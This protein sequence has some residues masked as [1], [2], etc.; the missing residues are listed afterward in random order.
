MS[1]RF[2]FI[3]ADYINGV[4]DDDGNCLIRP[5]TEEEK[6]FLNDFYAETVI[7]NFYHHP[8][9]RKLHNKKKALVNNDPNIKKLKKQSKVTK[10]K[11][12]NRRLKELVKEVKSQ[13]KE[14]H[15]ETIDEIDKEIEKIRKKVL[16]Y[17]NK[18][19]H[20]QFYHENNKRNRCVFNRSKTN[21]TIDYYDPED[22]DKLYNFSKDYEKDLIEL[23]ERGLYEDLED[24]WQKIIQ[25]EKRSKKPK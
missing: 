23:L 7:T 13:L 18:E 20:K 11:E 9:L 15:K 25:A 22:Y 17:P 12:E 8:E 4:Y 5:C 24:E 1:S 2:D 14:K 21:F 16:L 10:D 6:R 19:D 3:E